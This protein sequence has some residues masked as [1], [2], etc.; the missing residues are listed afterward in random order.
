MIFKKLGSEEKCQTMT[1]NF[2]QKL[3]IFKNQNNGGN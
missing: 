3:K 2:G 1:K